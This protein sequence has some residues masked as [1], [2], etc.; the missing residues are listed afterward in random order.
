MAHPP[1]FNLPAAPKGVEHLIELALDLRGTWEHSANE[2]WGQLDPELWRLTLNPWA[3]LQA[4]SHA[5][6][7]ALAAD[8]KFRQ[9]VAALA[10][11][12]AI[13][14]GAD[15]VPTPACRCPADQRGL[16]QH[17]VHAQRSATHLLGGTWKCGR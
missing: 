8:S 3:V 6:L 4:V 2:L 16:F 11:P 10:R 9:K 1:S 13:F 12:A 15:V 17:G 5:K 7:K 14:G